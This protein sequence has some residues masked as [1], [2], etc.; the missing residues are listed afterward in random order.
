MTLKY[1]CLIID[2]DDTAVKSSPEIHYPCFVK[3]IETFRPGE[4][5]LTLQEFMNVCFY[6]NLETYYK[7]ELGFTKEELEL[8][9]EMWRKY[10]AERV[11]HF[12]E[13]IEEIL[14]DLK[15]A[16]GVFAVSSQSHKAVIERDYAARTSVAPDFIYGCEIGL[17]NCKPSPFTVIDVCEKAGLSPSD[18]LI[19]DDLKTG[20]EM[21]RRS[22]AHFAAAGWSHFVP[23]IRR[24]M[25]ENAEFYL[26]T[27]DELKA[28][29]FE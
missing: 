6:P 12:Y 15:A 22:G 8:E 10:V 17:G 5:I 28:L 18:V 23:E 24:Y 26:R 20:L 7:N 25:K 16:G 27:T 13:G 29:I 19:V 11:P 9:Y 2:H 4:Y 3:T 14:T 1:K 21:A